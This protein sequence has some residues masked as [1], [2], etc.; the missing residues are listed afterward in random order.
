M[1]VDDINGKVKDLCI[2]DNNYPI[3]NPYL[4][5]TRCF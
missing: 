1:K 5:Q 3:Y 2:Y 4:E